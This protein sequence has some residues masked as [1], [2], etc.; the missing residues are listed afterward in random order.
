MFNF[1]QY[2]QNFDWFAIV[3][4]IVLIGVM[5][6]A[7]LFFIYKRNIR[8][9]F[10]LLAVVILNVVLNIF[11][12]VRGTEILTISR[13]IAHYGLLFV[14]MVVAVT[15]KSDWKSFVHKISNPH[16]VDL[17]SQGFGSDDELR[18]ATTEILTACQNMAKQDIGAI[19][20]ITRTE[21][22]P[23]NITDTGTQIGA[24]LTA[25]LL[26]SIF[27]TKAPLHDGAVIVR[28]NKILTAGC[29]LPLTQQNLSKDMGTRHR[30]AVGISEEADV[31]SIVVSE[32]TGIISTVKDGNIKR[33][34]TMEKLKEE[35]EEAFG[36]SALD[37]AQKAA[38]SEKRSR[39]RM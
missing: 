25:G 19:I 9:L 8:V 32:E 13:S 17:Y 31:L 30:A 12:Y 35:I 2:F 11:Y 10:I 26:E 22:V 38:H 23:T 16:G 15:Y 33:Y 28:G 20:V 7:I 14:L 5:A 24:K 36:I 21:Q 3:D 4:A 39:R 29:F 6:L 1:Y 27:N 34:I 37:L 18:D